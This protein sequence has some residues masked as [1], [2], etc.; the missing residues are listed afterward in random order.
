LLPGGFWLLAV[1]DKVRDFT[2]PWP[3][4]IYLHS[5]LCNLDCSLNGSPSSKVIQDILSTS[6]DLVALDLADGCLDLLTN[7]VAVQSIA[8][9]DHGGLT[10]AKFVNL[11]TH[12]H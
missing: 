5:Q 3:N 9:K 7:T 8:S 6:R 11:H 12:K 1:A 10:S 2:E 4:S